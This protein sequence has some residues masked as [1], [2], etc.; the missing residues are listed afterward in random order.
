MFITENSIV[1]LSQSKV[2]G[3]ALSPE[4]DIPQHWNQPCYF[5]YLSDVPL[6]DRYSYHNYSIIPD[7]NERWTEQQAFKKLPIIHCKWL[8]QSAFKTAMPLEVNNKYIKYANKSGNIMMYVKLPIAKGN[9][10]FVMT[11]PHYMTATKIFWIPY[12][13]AKQ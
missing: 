5:Q 12:I 4:R 10:V 6:D 9:Y 8:P 13:L 1:K 11:P 7:N 2:Y 3:F